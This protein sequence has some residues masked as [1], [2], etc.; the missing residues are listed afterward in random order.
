MEILNFCQKE[1]QTVG[2][3]LIEEYRCGEKIR[4]G[5]NGP[6]DD[7]ETTVRNLSHL[8]VLTS[9]EIKIFDN[10]A[11]IEVLKK[12]GE[13]LLSLK[14]ERGLF[15]LRQKESKDSCNGVIGHAWVIEALVYL[16]N[17]LHER[18]YIDAAVII[19]KQHVFDKKL[20]LW[21]RP[22]YDEKVKDKIDYTL[23]HQLWYAASLAELLKVNNDDNLEQELRYFMKNLH[24]SFG[25]ANN[26]RILHSVYRRN[27]FKSQMKQMI[28]KK[29]HL[30]EARLGKPSMVYKEQ[31]YHVFNL[32]ALSRIY[33][34]NPEYVFFKNKKFCKALDYVNT[35][36]FL[37]GLENTKICLDNSL[38]NN[39][40][41]K[42][43]LVL[44]IYGYP[45]NV[46]GFELLYVGKVFEKK[47]S[48]NC[49]KECLKK[50][51]EFTYEERKKQFGK[52]CHDKNTVN[53]RVYEYYRY[54]EICK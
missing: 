39:I 24:K 30:L 31:G 40:T 34:T 2:Q 26:G 32:M 15:V 7:S 54:L 22:I 42:E 18:K 5:I 25:V 11:Y 36:D 19:A 43:E 14:D 6:Y 49:I 48:E 20:C 46:P 50:Q 51:F 23:N 16:Y 13:E 33:M 9:V 35:N 44:N 38:N 4:Q 37:I 21:N 3:K 12:M 17:V 8:I 29:I 53:Y 28:K 52:S 45:Y 47:V 1:I 10:K 41:D 27:E